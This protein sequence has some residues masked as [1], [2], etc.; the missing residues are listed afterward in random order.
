MK[1]EFKDRL[2]SVLA[3]DRAASRAARQTE[4]AIRGATPFPTGSNG[5]PFWGNGQNQL[6]TPG[7]SGQKRNYAARVGDLLD[8][9]PIGVC[10]SWYANNFPDAIPVV[11]AIGAEDMDPQ[12]PAALLWRRPN[13]AMSYSV[14]SSAVVSSLWLTGEAYLI[15]ARAGDG[16]TGQTRE[17][18]WRPPGT[19]K[20]VR[21]PGSGNYIDHFEYT[22]P[23]KS[24]AQKIPVENVIYLRLGINPKDEIRGYTPVRRLLLSVFNDE[25][26]DL[27]AAAI[28]NN[29]G[30]AGAVYRHQP[31][32]IQVG[33]GR[34]EF[35][36]L[37][38]AQVERVKQNHREKLTGA[39]KGEAIVLD[40]F[41]EVD[42]PDGHLDSS[43]L[44]KIND[45]SEAAIAAAFNLPPVL[46]NFLVGLKHGNTR[47]SHEDARRQGY[48]EGMVPFQR[49]IA[50]DLDLYLLPEFADPDRF[51]FG[52]DYS[53]VSVMQENLD[54]IAKRSAQ[55]YTGG[56]ITRAEAREMNRF[57]SDP[58]R[59]DT[60]APAPGA[61][62]KT[63]PPTE[64]NDNA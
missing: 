43:F 40:G 59:D 51:S 63:D 33:G 37:N 28:M 62:S 9:N 49:S 5:T 39:N 27:A 38:Q 32:K 18:W 41:W 12:H 19:M 3:Q 11:T 47:A 57:I 8:S 13:L 61:T 15:K 7:G 42:F 22:P 53:R 2:I 23:G 20:P 25:E 55:L 30:V 52:F 21:I 48:T 10:I 54:S 64:T 35:V 46:V 56:I 1:A 45:I 34:E 17:L 31:Q 36:H 58:T 60:F 16:I 4:S 50:E 24:V 6:Y 29:I 26:A 44:E 14:Q